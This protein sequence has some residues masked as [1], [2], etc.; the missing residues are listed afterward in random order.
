MANSKEMNLETLNDRLGKFWGSK[1]EVCERTGFNREYVR[2]VLIGER[3]SQ[4]VIEAAYEVLLEY[5]QRAAEHRK[6]V[7]NMEAK[8]R[9]LA[10]S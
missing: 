9:E 3:N 8:V 1:K 5:E 7:R 6:R 10:E 4:K 2:L